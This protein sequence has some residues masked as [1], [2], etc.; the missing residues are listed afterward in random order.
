MSIRE[1]FPALWQFL[2]GY[3]HQDWMNDAPDPSTVVDLFLNESNREQIAGVLSELTRLLNQDC[4]D[5]EL[6]ALLLKIGCDV[7]FPFFGVT[8]RQWLVSVRG[9]IFEFATAHK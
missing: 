8:A 9:Q 1:D 7:H 2:G 4:S 3:F 5:D 6:Q